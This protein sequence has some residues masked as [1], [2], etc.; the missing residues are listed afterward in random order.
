MQRLYFWGE[1]GMELARYFRCN[2]IL[3]WAG[4]WSDLHR[5][6]HKPIQQQFPPDEARE[7]FSM[8]YW[9]TLEKAF[10]GGSY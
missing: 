8:A 7:D 5:R 10:F 9:S 1:L 2:L 3:D 4:D 6:I